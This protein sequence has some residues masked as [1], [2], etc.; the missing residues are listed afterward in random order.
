M[1]HYT[2][3]RSRFDP[4][5]V[6][7]AVTCPVLILAGED[8]PL[9]PP[10]VAEDLAER[11]PAET[12]RLVR[13]P[14]ARHTIFR[15]RPD[16]AFPAVRNFV[17]SVLAGSLGAGDAVEPVAEEGALGGGE[18]GEVGEAAWMR[19]T[20]RRSVMR[21]R[22]ASATR[23]TRSRRTLTPAAAAARPS[24]VRSAMCRSRN[25]SGLASPKPC[26]SSALGHCGRSLCPPGYPLA[27]PV[28]H[29]LPWALVRGCGVCG[30]WRS[31]GAGCAGCRGRG[32]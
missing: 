2:H 19:S 17:T 3:E 31:G 27:Y 24:G 29:A 23:C 16:L 8:D 5:S 18:D 14:G 10:P 13:L 7:G 30:G 6:T 21:S 28:G 1:S 26:E 12:T 25:S 11:L 32:S 9:C 15:D 22:P 20:A 4:W